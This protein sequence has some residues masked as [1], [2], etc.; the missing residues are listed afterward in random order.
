MVN[1]TK[2]L[3]INTDPVIEDA[4]E[5]LNSHKTLSSENL[6]YV[7]RVWEDPGIRLAYERRDE[8]QLDS[9][10]IYYFENMERFIQPDFA[11]NASDILNLRLKTTA[12][13]ETHFISGEM[14]YTLVDVGGQR[15]ERRKWL[16]CFDSVGA[17]IYIIAL[18]EYNM[19]LNED[20]RVNRLQE[21]LDLFEEITDSKNFLK[22]HFFVLFNKDDLFRDKIKTHPISNYFE[23][24]TD[25]DTY[26]N[27]L[28]FIQS[29]FE[30]RFHGNKNRFTSLV[31]TL[32]DTDNFS[33]TLE[34]INTFYRET[35]NF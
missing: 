26:D 19:N 31:T 8:F 15:C 16:P 5:I 21:A 11:P 1:A 6:P 34:K 7:K 3:N 27:C 4:I 18:D 33:K 29:Q 17:V 14:E 30:Q 12:V 32:L 28:K 20:Y 2:Q 22:T 35:D 23:E 13:T 25:E 24:F 10:A 9:N